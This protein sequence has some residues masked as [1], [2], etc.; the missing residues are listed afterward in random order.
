MFAGTERD[1]ATCSVLNQSVV[2][3]IP[4]IF[5]WETDAAIRR[6]YKAEKQPL[7]DK[8]PDETPGELLDEPLELGSVKLNTSESLLR[9]QSSMSGKLQVSRRSV[10]QTKEDLSSMTNQQLLKNGSCRLHTKY[11][12]FQTCS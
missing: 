12:E 5:R 3:L 4:S 7:L 9:S 6:S 11:V 1:C 8:P 2:L 10:L